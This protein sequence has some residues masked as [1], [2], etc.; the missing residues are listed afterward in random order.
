MIV[1]IHSKFSI[2]GSILLTDQSFGMKI[3]FCKYSLFH[4]I[5]K[6]AIFAKFCNCDI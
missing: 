2:I 6:F 1:F 3:I 5:Q 4:E